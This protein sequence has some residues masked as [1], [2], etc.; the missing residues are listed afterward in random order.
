MSSPASVPL[1]SLTTRITKGTTPTTL[2]YSFEADGVNYVKS[3]SI[4][5]Q[6]QI[7][8]SKFAF[9][10]PETHQAL[11][12]SILAEGDVLFSMA[13]VYLGKTAVVPESILPANTNQAVGVIRLDRSKALPRFVHYALSSPRCRAIVRGGVA[14]SAQ[15]NINL[16]DIGKLPI[17]AFPIEEQQRIAYILGTLDDKIELNRRINRTLESIA[18]AIFKSW[19]VDFD[20]VHAKAE[21]LDPV[22]M[23]SA[24]AALFPDSFQD[25]PLGKIPKGW[26][27]GVLEGLVELSRE[28]VKPQEYPAEEFDHYSIPAHDS[29]RPARDLGETIRSSKYLVPPSAVLISKLNPHIPRVWLLQVSEERCAICSTEFLVC[30]PTEVVSREYIYCLLSSA[31]FLD[32]F[33]QM[34][35]G[36]TGS[37]QRVRPTAFIGMEV[38][39]PPP[40][41]LSA[42]GEIA[43]PLLSKCAR[44]ASESSKL[45]ATRDALLPRLL[46]GELGASAGPGGAG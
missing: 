4:T 11:E 39:K 26:G 16:G 21:G 41:L 2:G 30:V 31:T 14:Q 29:G 6:G 20:P 37:H 46:A 17:P 15:P 36:T 44:Q 10:S 13:G 33:A 40:E 32:R 3:E 24:T 27:V 43:Q 28:S 38:A 8:T 1:G 45:A 12:R 19:F 18:R 42:F 9:I 23:D 22:G 25:S 34:V 35:T 7:D 5:D